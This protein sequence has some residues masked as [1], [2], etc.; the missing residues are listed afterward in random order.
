LFHSST[1]LYQTFTV[2]HLSRY[3]IP[4][5]CKSILRTLAV[6]FAE[7]NFYVTLKDVCTVGNDEFS[8]PFNLFLSTYDLRIA[9]ITTAA[10]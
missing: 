10:M 1:Q 9:L 5:V 6:L 7:Y 8:M 2:I 4:R 3:S